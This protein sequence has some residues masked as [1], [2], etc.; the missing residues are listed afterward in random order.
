[1]KRL[2]IVTALMSEAIP[3]IDFYRMKKQGKLPFF[4]WF[5]KEW[6]ES[7]CCGL[8]GVD[9]LVC[10]MGGDK[11]YRGLKAY[12]TTLETVE[13][14]IYLNF[15]IAGTSCNPIGALLWADSIGD[16]VIGVPDGV[17]NT[18]SLTVC[19][20]I[21]PSLN[22]QAGVLFDMEAEAWLHCIADNTIQ[23][24]PRDL[25]CAKVVSDNRRDNMHKID[26]GWVSDIVRQNMPELDK[27][28]NKLIKTL[29]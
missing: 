17:H 26:K 16:V 21:E 10:G 3:L 12:L 23:F 7:P 24:A 18:P 25:F 19:S 15:G 1:M 20:L 9:L 8:K 29:G 13:D 22:Y 5:K 14:I 6:T 4:H 28:I 2:L 11:M 27:G